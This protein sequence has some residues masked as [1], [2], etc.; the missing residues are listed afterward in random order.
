MTNLRGLVIAGAPDDTL[1]LGVT[2]LNRS[3]IS[4]INAIE[5]GTELTVLD[6]G[7]GSGTRTQRIGDAEITW[8]RRGHRDGRR[9]WRTDNLATMQ[10]MRR[11][12]LHVGAAAP[13]KRA[14]AVLDIGGGD[15]FADLYG[16]ERF[17]LIADLRQLVLAIGTPL[18]LLPQTYGPF[19]AP[20]VRA[21]AQDI[22]V[23]SSMAWAR[24]ADSYCALRDLVGDDFDERRHREGVDVAFGLPP[25]EPTAPEAAEL[26][27]ALRPGAVGLNVSGLIYND[28]EAR[29]RYGHVLDYRKVT[30][31]IVRELLDHGVEQLVLVPH[32]LAEAGSY[33]RDRTACEQVLETFGNDPRIVI[34]PDLDADEVKYLIGRLHWFCGTRMHATIAALSS[35]VPC[36]TVAYSLKARGVFASCSAAHN[37]ADARE[38]ADADAVDVVLASYRSA[39][40]DRPSIAAAAATLSDAALA[41]MADIISGIEVR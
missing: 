28:P 12:G 3:T 29:E 7:R 33:E 36:A 11:I 10:A 35:G 1:N 20:A 31:Q 15:S 9:Y 17:R 16:V 19:V 5:P 37:V 21:E 32:V 30:N 14:A 22:V 6:Y 38:L 23:R 13:I 18:V 39:D 24:D 2:A 4:A 34:A 26:L 8:T 41:Q 25:R 40:E 27:A